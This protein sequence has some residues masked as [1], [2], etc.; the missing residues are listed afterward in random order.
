[1]FF[2]SRGGG[3]VLYLSYNDHHVSRET[4]TNAHIDHVDI[5]FH[6]GASTPKTESE[7]KTKSYASNVIFTDTL[8]NSL[9][10]IPHKIIFA[11]TVCVYAENGNDS[12]ISE[13]TLIG[14]SN[15]YGWSKIMC[16][17]ILREYSSKN[18]SQICILRFGQ[19]Y[20]DGEE[21]RYEK[22]VSSFL[23]RILKKQDITLFGNGTALKSQLYVKDAI[24]YILAT[25]NISDRLLIV[26]IAAGQSIS[27]IDIIRI[28]ESETGREAN[29]SYDNSH[30]IQDVIY[31]IRYRNQC[32]PQIQETPYNIGIKNFVDYYMREYENANR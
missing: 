23:K 9:P 29:I 1:M 3:E 20:G 16:E 2:G 5:V 31:D 11:S 7:I 18:A 14:G 4:F 10:S 21:K 32:F 6:L 15:G 28:L 17:D 8:L 13:S 12:I 26:N 25:L 27:L 30:L 22:I 24:E 19:I